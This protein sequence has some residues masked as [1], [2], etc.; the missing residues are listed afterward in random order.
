MIHFGSSR[1]RSLAFVTLFASATGTASCSSGAPP[2][3]EA[4]EQVSSPVVK[5][6]A[7]GSLIIP[8]DT[9]YQNTGTL[10]AFGLVYDLLKKGVPVQWVVQTGKAQGGNDF[11]ATAKDVASGTTLLP[12]NYRG[13]PFIIDSTNRAAALPII[14]AWIAAH[15]ATHVHDAVAGFSADV[16]KTLSAAPKIAV[17][18]DTNEIIAFRYLNAAFIPDSTGKAWPTAADAT[19]TYAAWPDVINA[20]EAKGATS[21][22]PADGQLLRSDGTPAYCQLTSM[23]YTTAEEEV[24]R[25]V[26]LWLTSSPSTHAFME[27]QAVKSFENAVNGRFL[28]TAGLTDDGAAPA[29]ITNRQPDSTF[30]QYDG[31]FTPVA[32]LVDSIGLAPTSTFRTTDV[33]LI[34]QSISPTTQRIVWMTGFVDGDS[35]KGKVSYLAGHDY[36]TASPITT[37]AATNGTRLFL[38]SLFESNCAAATGAPTVTLTKSA[39][40]AISGSTL[41]FTLAYAN[42]GPGIAD[43]AVLTD[44]IPSGTTF[45][46][47]T[48]PCTFTAPT[49]TCNLG[50]LKVGAAGS[51]TITV[52]VPTDGT[53][54]NQAKLAYKVSLTD[55]SVT[56]NTTTTTRTAAVDAGVDTGTPD[57]GLVDTG[58]ILDT[59]VADTTVA[60]TAVADTTVAD[61]TGT[62]TAVPDSGALDTGGGIDSTIADTGGGPDAAGDADAGPKDSDGD[63]LSDVD[64]T[65][66]GTDPFDKDSDDDGVLDGD[67]PGWNEDSDGDGLINA[68]DPDSDNDGLLDGTE[69]GLGCA[70]PATDVSKKHCRADADPST[71]TDPLK[72]DTDGGGASD[73][74]EDPNLDG[75]LDTGET[76]PTDGHGADDS[77]VVD[78]DK[79]GLGDLLEKTLGSNPNDADSDDDGTPD[80]KEPNPSLDDD[81]D[82][83][84]DVLDPDSDG[85]G[86]K[87]GTEMGLGCDDPATDK[88]KGQCVPDADPSTKTS[89]LIADTD[90]G[91]V[92]DGDEDTN[93]DGKVETGE[94]DPLDPKDDLPGGD[95]GDAGDASITDGGD[96]GRD[97]G[98]DVSTDASEGDGA[99][100][101]DLDASPDNGASLA[102]G[103]CNCEIPA[104]DRS[105][106]APLA[107]LLA[108]VALVA[109]RRR[110]ILR[111][112]RSRDR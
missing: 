49:V 40:A 87:D 65:A 66:A 59:A 22:G 23:H 57:T 20:T 51:V 53:Y 78:T 86:L 6:F 97:T 19:G 73:G 89:P 112:G 61:T 76:D 15:P 111:R 14:T 27:C 1:A 75:K 37:N 69:L 102:G 68:L 85:D 100:D 5:A 110:G 21:T 39:P 16:R 13:G 95:A 55:A 103:G 105:G 71:T 56:S 43:S 107:A 38:D 9:T 84:I 63:G 26:R 62:D 58:T 35:T 17:F 93:H 36:G 29:L 96:S 108:G 81:H 25:E 18:V 30:A 92:K 52:N 60:D 2:A 24:V 50:N 64:E 70:N 91:G 3:P 47:A 33:V 83:L 82:G 42:T 94:R 8:M 54:S 104:G 77:S 67:E 31:N 34:N 11:T 109:A 28:T 10:Q 99:V 45:V 74:S 101:S 98:G 90:H 41:T 106:P 44:T 4:T 12:H 72:W 7:I 79:D 80:G 32:G 88:S 46:S 48:A